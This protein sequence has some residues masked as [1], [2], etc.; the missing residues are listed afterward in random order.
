MNRLNT[1]QA[2]VFK[3]QNEEMNYIYIMQICISLPKYV[4]SKKFLSSVSLPASV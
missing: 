1:E 3:K 4:Y 2:P